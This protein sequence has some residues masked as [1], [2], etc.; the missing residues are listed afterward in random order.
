MSD[1]LLLDEHPLVIQPA[2]AVAVGLNEAIVLQQIH[3]WLQKRLNV[4]EGDA[5]VYNSVDKWQEQFPFWSYDTVKRT[6]T[7]LEKMGLLITGNFNKRGMDR[8]KWYRI[9]YEVLST[10]VLP[11]GQNAPMIRADCTDHQGKM[12]RPIPETTPETTTKTNR[13]ATRRTTPPK[14]SG[15]RSKGYSKFNDPEY[16]YELRSEN[17]A[18]FRNLLMR[19]F[20]YELGEEDIPALASLVSEFGKVEIAKCMRLMRKEAGSDWL[21]DGLKELAE[22]G[23]ITWG[24]R[25]LAD[26]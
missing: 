11:L 19:L 23:G 13:T 26:V 9:D 5:W 24:L 10:F 18:Y 22:S 4:V 7:K 2:L 1:K 20:E 25:C 16:M 8:T 3:Y 15:A 6:I 14:G 12:H 21:D 17:I